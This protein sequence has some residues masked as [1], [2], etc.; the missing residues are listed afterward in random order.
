MTEH[1]HTHTHTHTH[2]LT[3]LDA[4]DL[5]LC[6]PVVAI[7]DVWASVFLTSSQGMWI[8]T[9]ALVHEAGHVISPFQSR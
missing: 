4:W 3:K 2:L 6:I 8:H 1:T 5:S 7:A 9:I